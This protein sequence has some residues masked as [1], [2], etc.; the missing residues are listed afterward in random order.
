MRYLLVLIQQDDK[1][2]LK[3]HCKG[4]LSKFT[5]PIVVKTGTWVQEK[6]KK[7]FYLS[8]NSIARLLLLHSV[9]IK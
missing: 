3:A 4:Q 9:E 1:P 6:R 2:N 8:G 7:V 5:V